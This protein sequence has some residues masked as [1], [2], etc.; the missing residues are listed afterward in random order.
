MHGRYEDITN[1]ACTFTESSQMIGR[2]G[3][4]R[5]RACNSAPAASRRGKLRSLLGADRGCSWLREAGKSYTRYAPSSGFS[6]AHQARQPCLGA[7]EQG[8][9]AASTRPGAVFS[10]GLA[11][12]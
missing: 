6:A 12:G 10:P 3:R 4:E 8:S 2:S 5:T 11:P 1:V 9:E 7:N